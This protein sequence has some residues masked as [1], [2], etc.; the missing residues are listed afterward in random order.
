MDIGMG[1]NRENGRRRETQGREKMNKVNSSFQV[2]IYISFVGFVV[3]L[4]TSCTC[5][6]FVVISVS[7]LYVL[8]HL[9][10]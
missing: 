9:D 2:F 8:R 6:P 5:V 4:L 10:H 3:L 1:M 7:S